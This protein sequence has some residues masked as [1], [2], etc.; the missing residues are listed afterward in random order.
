MV[1]KRERVEKKEKTGVKLKIKKKT[2]EK[3][4]KKMAWF[5]SFQHLPHTSQ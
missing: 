2:L 4:L 5:P 1:E 3:Q